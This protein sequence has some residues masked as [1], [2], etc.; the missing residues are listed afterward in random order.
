MKVQARTGN[1]VFDQHRP[2]YWQFSRR[3]R[4]LWA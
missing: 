1:R 4:M 3:W 2:W